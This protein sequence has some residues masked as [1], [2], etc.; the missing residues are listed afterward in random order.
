MSEE[1]PVSVTL[2]FKNE[3]EKNFFMGG[4]SDG[5]GENACSLSWTYENYPEEY[6]RSGKAFEEQTD[7]DV[8]VFGLGAL[9]REELMH[10]H[11]S[12]GLTTEEQAEWDRREENEDW[13][14]EEETKE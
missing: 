7:F 5:W 3:A 14:N 2:H 12:E 4:L 6:V 9:R 13:E 10:K 1:Y 11:F 8:I